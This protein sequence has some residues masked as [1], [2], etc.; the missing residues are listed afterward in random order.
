MKK[1]VPVFALAV[2]LAGCGGDDSAPAPLV[3]SDV[4]TGS[5]TT[6]TYSPSGPSCDLS[7]T[8]SASMINIPA[9]TALID[10]LLTGSTNILS[11]GA[12]ATVSGDLV[13]LGS[14]NTVITNTTS[15]ITPVF[16]GAGNVLIRN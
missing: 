2:M 9:G 7:L 14:D 11:F 5:S 12:G 13:V 10:V 8:F 3:C 15:A 6:V 1:L 4:L 16:T